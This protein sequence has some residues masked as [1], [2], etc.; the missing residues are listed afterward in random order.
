MTMPS[1]RSAAAT[2]LCLAAALVSAI[3]TAAQDPSPAQVDA[4]FQEFD[5]SDS[6]GCVL[7]VYRDGELVYES[8]YGMA[9]LDWGIEIDPSTVFY[10]GSVSKQFTAAAIALL[11][12]GGQLSLGDD[13]RKFLPELPEYDATVTVGHLV[14]H[15]GGMMDMYA[16]MMDSGMN[17]FDPIE[18]AEAIDVLASKPLDFVPGDR[19]SYSNGGYFLLSQI[20]ERVSGMSFTDFT[21]TNIFEPLGM[22]DTHF[23]GDAGH[24]VS[25]RAMSYEAGDSGEYRQ[26]YVSTF[27]FVGQGGL[28]TTVGDLIKW[29]RNFYESRVGGAGFRGFVETPGVLNDGEAIDYAFGLR[30]AEYRGQPT[31]GHSGGMMGFRAYMERFPEQH[32]TVSALCNQGEINPGALS[33]KVADLYL[34]D[35]LDPDSK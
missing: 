7:G 29:D 30:H 23:H 35:V 9:N 31:V 25:R 17:I 32:F 22:S 15:T 1:A 16:A 20:V 11:A 21:T 18:N 28:Y 14:H 3:P 33:R 27:G 12:R 4:I 5:R 2:S 34:A 8:G 13:I 24:I 26:N 19:F 6:P 10:V